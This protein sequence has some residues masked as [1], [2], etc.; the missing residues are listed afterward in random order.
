[1]LNDYLCILVNKGL[2]KKKR[3]KKSEMHWFKSRLQKL[4]HVI[5]LTKQVLQR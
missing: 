5:K 1:M 2:K 4:F 3:K